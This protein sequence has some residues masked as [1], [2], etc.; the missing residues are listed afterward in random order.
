MDK[1]SEFK[2]VN[3]ELKVVIQ[4]IVLSLCFKI[5]QELGVQQQRVCKDFNYNSGHS[6]NGVITMIRENLDHYDV[7]PVY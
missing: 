2:K 5:Q 1:K 7:R 4:E 3:K 6:R